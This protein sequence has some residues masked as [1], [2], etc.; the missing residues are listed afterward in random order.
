[1]LD[2]DLAL[3]LLS[4]SL[5]YTE[6]ESLPSWTRDLK[7]L[8]YLYETTSQASAE[9]TVLVKS[10]TLNRQFLLRRVDTRHIEG[11]P[12]ASN[13]RSLP[14]DLFEEMHNLAFLHLGLHTNLLR[15]PSL[16]GLSSLKQALIV[17]LFSITELPSFAPLQSLERLALIYLPS[18]QR[19]PD[20]APLTR[21]WQFMAVLPMQFCCN[22]FLGSCDLTHPYCAEDA[23]LVIPQARCLEDATSARATPGTMAVMDKYAALVCSLHYG[24]I[25]ETPTQEI[26]DMCAGVPYRK[27]EMP[28]I[29]TD[30]STVLTMGVCLN[31][32]MQVLACNTDPVKVTVR[33]LQIQRKV[34]PVCD[35]EVEA[36]LGC[37]RV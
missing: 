6:I 23:A 35:P 19:I 28:T 22:G 37:P 7:K 27:C 31:T 16:Q 20:M 24:L 5:L 21:L 3:S 15:L 33:R 34:G 13:L 18:L 10:L 29:Q 12:G 30:G 26:A 36:W 14:A 8:E 32:R 11:K 2:T 1:M 9:Q 17:Y 4:S 25:P